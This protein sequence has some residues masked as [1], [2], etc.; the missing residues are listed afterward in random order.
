MSLLHWLQQNFSQPSAPVDPLGL[1]APLLYFSKSDPWRIGDACEGTQIFGATGSGK[2]SGSGAAIARA[3]LAAGF[4]GLVL[5]AKTE[6]TALWK[7]YA[8]QTGREASLLVV[9]PASGQRFNFLDYE[10]RRPGAGAGLTENLVALFSNILEASGRK[11]Q[12]SDS[13]WQDALKQ[14][15]RNAIDLLA[16]AKGSVTL[17][18]L[19]Q[20]IASAPQSREEVRAQA[21]QEESFCFQC[22]AE[23]EEKPK[24]PGQE[25]DFNLAA[26]YWLSEFPSLA[27]KTRSIIVSSFTSMADGFLRGL[28]ADLFCTRT[29]FVP[30]LSQEGAII[31]LDLPVRQFD[32]LGQAAQAMFKFIWQRAME[33]RDPQPSLR[34]VFLWVDEAQQFATSYDMQFQATARSARVCTV[35][36]G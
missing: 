22:V 36:T 8:Q 12:S 20:L 35:C 19:Y 3:F 18:E 2:T 31:V 33:R 6:E 10:Y 9:S 5:T 15:L 16:I 26:R 7:R 27:A 21:W 34:P 24:T 1:D 30:E 25:R 13:Y 32:K 4:G 28:M 23:G 29:T 14:L 17:P 11:E